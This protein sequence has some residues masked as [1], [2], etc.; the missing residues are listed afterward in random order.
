LFQSWRSKKAVKL[1][2]E[3]I[4]N[5]QTALAMSEVETVG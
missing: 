2:M 3:A 4:D 1:R 5:M